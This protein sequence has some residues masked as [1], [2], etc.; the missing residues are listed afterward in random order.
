MA[1]QETEISWQ[2]LGE[3]VREWAGTG[4]ELAEVRTLS[5][6]SIN[7]TVRLTLKDGQRVV[8][9]VSPHRVDRSYGAEAHQL[10]LLREAGVPVPA[11]HGL[12][13]GSLESPH[14]YILLEFVEG[15]DLSEARRTASAAEFD[16]L[17]E[18]LA[19]LVLRI[20]GCVGERYCRALPE[21]PPGR[22]GACGVTDASDWASFYRSVYDPIWKEAER[23]GQLPVKCRKRIGR[24]HE[25]LE[26]L[27]A[28]EDQPRL[29]HWDLW[30]SNVLASP[31]ASGEWK[32]AAILDPNC[33]YAHSEAEIAYMELFHTITPAFLK[34]YQRVRK[35]PPEYQRVRRTVYMLYPLLEHLNMFGGDYHR[36]VEQASERLSAFA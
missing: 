30:S 4:A 18:E 8:A 11:V 34:C 9:K 28:Q 14:S 31:A 24:V 29:A 22:E 17:Q 16:V 1:V 19:E 12:R 25:R 35:L 21:Q 27:L 36:Q 10:G 23:N 6:G 26:T 5:G 33:K 20:H 15:V 3:I 32:I 7:N 13:L 2:L